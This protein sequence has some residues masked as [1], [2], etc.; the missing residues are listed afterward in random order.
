MVVVTDRSEGGNGSIKLSFNK[1][2]QHLR[3]FIS[4]RLLNNLI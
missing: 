1:H 3:E 2:K 4:F